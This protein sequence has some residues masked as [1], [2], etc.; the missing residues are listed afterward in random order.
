MID[1]KISSKREEYEVRNHQAQGV[2]GAW[3]R[4][5]RSGDRSASG[6]DRQPAQRH[7]A[8]LDRDTRVGAE[9]CKPNDVIGEINF[10]VGFRRAR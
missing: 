8:Q 2:N 7:N 10:G 6:A 1:R 4:L 3:R 5:M 9:V